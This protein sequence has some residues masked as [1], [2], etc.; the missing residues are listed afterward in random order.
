MKILPRGN[1]VEAHDHLLILD[2]SIVE[3]ESARSITSEDGMKYQSSI[4]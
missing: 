4:Y 2:S 1:G 3:L